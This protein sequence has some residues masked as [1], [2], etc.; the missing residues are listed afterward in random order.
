MK[1]FKSNSLADSGNQFI[2]SKGHAAIALYSVLT[3]LGK[4]SE[5][6]LES[7]CEDGS[8]FYGHIN[9]LAHPLIELSTGSLG[10]GMPYGV[11]LAHANLMNKERG[12]VFVLMSDGELDEGTTWESALIANKLKLQNLICVIDRNYMQSLESTETT[13]PLEPLKEKWK[14][15]GWDVIEVDGHN[16]ASLEKVNISSDKPKVLI[17]TTVKGKGVTWM[18]N[19]V[20]WHYKWPNDE[21]LNEALEILDRTLS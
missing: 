4:I 1:Y 9:H 8:Q 3:S 15:F 18:E 6:D 14:A 5:K 19:E 11:G 10:H 12:L 21:Q 2:L 16:F 13:L 20:S 7:F 17:A